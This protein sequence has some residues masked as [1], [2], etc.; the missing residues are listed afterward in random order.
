LSFLGGASSSAVLFIEMATSYLMR[1]ISSSKI[2]VDLTIQQKQGSVV[3]VVGLIV[4]SDLAA[5]LWV[6]HYV[7]LSS[8][9]VHAAKVAEEYENEARAFYHALSHAVFCCH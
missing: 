9:I 2:M 1:F 3:D 4:E 7:V 6:R 8:E 5:H